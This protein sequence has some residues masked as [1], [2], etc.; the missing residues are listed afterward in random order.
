MYSEHVQAIQDVLADAEKV[1]VV[2]HVNPDG[3]AYGSLTAVGQMLKQLGKTT[4]MAVDGGMFRRFEFLPVANEVRATA[5]GKNQTYDAVISVDCGDAGRMGRTFAELADPKP[6]LINIDHHITNTLFGEVNVVPPDACS[7]TAI[8]YEL[9]VEMGVEITEGIA[10]SLLTGIVTD[11]L[12]FRTNNVTARTLEVAG[13]LMRAGADLPN[14]TLNALNLQSYATVKM[15]REGL[16]NMTLEDELIWTTIS[17]QERQRAKYEGS[18]NAGLVSMIGNVSTASM[19]AVLIELDDGKVG[20]GFR[21]RPPFDVAQVAAELGGGGH[22]L[23]AGCSLDGPLK[24]AEQKVVTLCKDM[25]ISQR[26]EQG[27]PL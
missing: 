3:D 21:C 2:T 22:A 20:V 16:N 13:A 27:L 26:K 17:K 4:T 8:L 18:G 12:G 11:T 1:L 25:I 6:P 14:I 7:A 15:W 9:F 24:K 5:G 19:S 23:A 10:I